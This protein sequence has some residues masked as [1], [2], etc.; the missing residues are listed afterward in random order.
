MG[1]SQKYTQKLYSSR[2]IAK[3]VR[4]NIPFMWLSAQ[5][6]TDFR[7]IN[8]FRSKR[9]K[10]IID[11]VFSSVLQLLIEEG[12][13]KLEHYFLDGTKIEANANR[14]TFVWKKATEKHQA[15]L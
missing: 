11:E 2:Q 6:T 4:E 1:L 5:Q 15:K 8:R 3:P 13:V 7:T 9:M 12:Y 14:Y 10:E